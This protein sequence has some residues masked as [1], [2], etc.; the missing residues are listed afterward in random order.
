V[1]D[2]DT[3]SGAQ[4]V[5][6]FVCNLSSF[7]YIDVARVEVAHG[8]AHSQGTKRPSR[9]ADSHLLSRLR[10]KIT[11]LSSHTMVLGLTQPLTEINERNLP[12]RQARSEADNLTPSMSRLSSKCGSLDMSQSYRPPR[13]V[14][15]TDLSL[16]HCLLRFV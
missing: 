11:H 2:S 14:T 9:E 13:L 12:G 8:T 3:P 5:A 15:G 4:A 1:L 10:L 16:P 6:Q 7:V